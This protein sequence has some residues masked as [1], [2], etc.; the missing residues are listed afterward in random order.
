MKPFRQNVLLS[1]VLLT[2]NYTFADIALAS[3]SA[4]K[5]TTVVANESKV[6]S[7]DDWSDDSWSEDAWGDDDW[8]SEAASDTQF[9]APKIKFIEL[10]VGQRFDSD[11]L[12]KQQKTLR[13]LRT[14]FEWEKEWHQVSL[15]AKFDLVANAITKKFEVDVRELALQTAIGEQ[16]D[17]RVGKQVLSWGVGDY[18]FLN[19]LFPKNWQAFFNGRD[20]EYLK[21]AANAVQV[22]HYFDEGN[23][24][25]VWFPRFTPDEFVNGQYF[26]YFNP[27]QGA[28]SNQRMLASRSHDS[29]FAL[30][31]F[32]RFGSLE[33]A[34]YGHWGREK[35]PRSMQTLVSGLASA[36]SMQPFFARVNTYGASLSAA[37]LDGIVKAEVSYGESQDDKA[38]SNPF[39]SNSLLKVLVGYETE[40]AP[41]LTGSW[42]AYVE[43]EQ[44]FAAMQESWPTNMRLS[45]RHR[46]MLTQLYRYQLWQET[47]NINLLHMHSTSDKDGLV[48]V[49]ATYK[50]S[51]QWHIVIGG[52]AFYGHFQDSFFGQFEDAQNV[53]FRVRHY[54]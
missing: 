3:T 45:S 14:R 24:Q 43:A 54:W 27:L 47:L 51:D 46:V 12:R 9:M 36:D 2:A 6:G 34:L 7:E 42:Q 30:R 18:V 31:V 49:S 38:G 17:L 16:T 53:Y 28:L 4:E 25:I 37:A 8:G 48:R 29:E 39:I 21:A 10:G 40:L 22:S 20:D 23:A 35:T 44:N 32:K 50:A 26:N 33:A 11:V 13:E 19:D 41:K 52:N 15:E 5:P 1:I